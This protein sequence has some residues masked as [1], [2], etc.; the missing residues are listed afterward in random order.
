MWNAHSLGEFT[1]KTCPDLGLEKFLCQQ[2]CGSVLGRHQEAQILVGDSQEPLFH[3]S[4]ATL[5]LFSAF[6]IPGKGHQGP[7]CRR[8]VLSWFS[9]P[10]AL[11]SVE[12][13][14]SEQATELLRTSAFQDLS[15]LWD[16]PFRGPWTG[17]NSLS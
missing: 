7:G 8:I 13:N 5:R 2:P 1:L 3:P 11:T 4:A 9:W 14:A 16:T 12:V 6:Y 10:L 15:R 17:P